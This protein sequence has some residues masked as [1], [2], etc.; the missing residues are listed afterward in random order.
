MQKVKAKLRNLSAV[1]IGRAAPSSVHTLQLQ[2]HSSETKVKWLEK[3]VLKRVSYRRNRDS[4][5][6]LSLYSRD[7]FNINL[8]D[9]SA[10]EVSIFRGRSVCDA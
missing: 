10:E 3:R 5:G 9:F 6:H 7:A 1:N 8:A 4:S 2:Q